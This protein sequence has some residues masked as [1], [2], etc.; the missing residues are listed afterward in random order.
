MQLSADLLAKTN[1]LRQVYSGV[2]PLNRDGLFASL[3]S[4]IPGNISLQVTQNGVINWSDGS[5]RALGK[6]VAHDNVNESQS[7]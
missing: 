7:R 4:D 1:E 5:V 6:G 3:L 2:N